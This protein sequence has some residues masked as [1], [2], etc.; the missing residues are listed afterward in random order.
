MRSWRRR[1]GGG[2]DLRKGTNYSSIDMRKCTERRAGINILTHVYFPP[3]RT[4]TDGGLR[5][6]WPA[7]R[8]VV[9]RRESNFS[10]SPATGAAEIFQVL[11]V[12]RVA[13][14]KNKTNTKT[15][16]GAW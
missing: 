7:L 15:P 2:S 1:G 14:E 6:T 12:K 5:E 3:V 16:E 4:R 13:H 8:D 11:R 10:F 9:V